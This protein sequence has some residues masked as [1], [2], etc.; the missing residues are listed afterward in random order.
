MVK[1]SDCISEAEGGCGAGY[2]KTDDGWCNRII[3]KP[4][5]AAPLLTDDN[6]NSFTIIFK[7]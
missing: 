7:K 6:N 5:E 3:Y 4:D 1:G 2:I